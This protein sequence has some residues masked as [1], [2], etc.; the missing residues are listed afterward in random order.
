MSTSIARIGILSPMTEAGMKNWWKKL[1]EGRLEEL[2]YV[3]KVAISSSFGVSAMADFAIV[4]IASTPKPRKVSAQSR[5]E[6]R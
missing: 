1:K 6:S 5:T 4:N 2:G 3:A